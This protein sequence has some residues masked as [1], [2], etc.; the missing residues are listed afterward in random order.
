[1]QRRTKRYVGGVEEH[2]SRFLLIIMVGG[3]S[4]GCYERNPERVSKR[5]ISD[6]AVC[7]D[8]VIDAGEECDDGAMISF[9]GNHSPMVAFEKHR[10]NS[11]CGLSCDSEEVTCHGDLDGTKESCAATCLEQT[12]CL[13]FQVFSMGCVTFSDIPQESNSG[14]CEI[15]LM[16]TDDSTLAEEPHRLSCPD[17]ESLRSGLSSESLSLKIRNRTNDTLS[18]Y[19]LDFEGNRVFYGTFS[20]GE[21]FSIN[22]FSGHAW[23]IEDSK[24]RCRDVFYSTHQLDEGDI[25]LTKAWFDSTLGVEDWIKAIY[26]IT[27]VLLDDI[28]YLCSSHCKKPTPII[29]LGGSERVVRRCTNTAK[30]V[31]DIRNIGGDDLVIDKIEIEGG[32]WSHKGII[33]PLTIPPF[34]SHKLKLRG[35]GGSAEVKVWSNASNGEWAM[36]HLDA[37]DDF[38]P[39]VEILSPMAGEVL[40]MDLGTQVLGRVEDDFD[41]LQGLKVEFLDEKARRIHI[42]YPNGDGIVDFFWPSLDRKLGFQTVTM[43]VTDSCGNRGIQRVNVCQGLNNESRC[44]VVPL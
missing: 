1:M 38:A 37:T 15:D 30:A 28:P 9:G 7:G 14:E 32:Q 6:A 20:H 25:K 34:Q 31:I 13:A 44:G 4:T 40:A 8:G 11:M 2:T 39:T 10:L 17:E 22:T 12:E 43:M 23:L 3:I 35:N 36:I 42:S 26:S 29:S 5:N 41:L 18:F 27:Y 19:W 24:G 16:E 33:L 21:K